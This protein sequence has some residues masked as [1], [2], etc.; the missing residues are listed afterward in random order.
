M[1]ILILIV[2]ANLKGGEA[3]FNPYNPYWWMPNVAMLNRAAFG[4]RRRIKDVG[5]YIISTNALNVSD[6]SVD[7]GL[8][9]YIYNQL[10]CE[11]IV[12]FKFHTAVPAAAAALPVTVAIP[13]RNRTTLVT[14]GT[15]STSTSSTTVPVTDKDNNPV[16]GGDIDVVT[17]KLAYINKRTGVIKFTEFTTGD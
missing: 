12:L 3:M 5:I 17:E 9:P 4:N 15:T 10:P 1:S 13:N 14:T 7:F 11:A 16:V 8:D 6:T 2:V